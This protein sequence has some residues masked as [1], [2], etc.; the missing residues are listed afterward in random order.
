VAD[1]V[2]ANFSFEQFVIHSSKNS[3]KS[4]EKEEE[5]KSKEEIVGEVDEDEEDCPDMDDGFFDENYNPG[6]YD[7]YG[8]E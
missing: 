8:G 6:V 7:E 2:N 3:G 4:K 5:K 1:G